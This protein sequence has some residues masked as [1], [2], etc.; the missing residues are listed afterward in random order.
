MWGSGGKRRVLP[1]LLARPR[2]SP[3]RRPLR[4]SVP[5]RVVLS[6]LPEARP[7]TPRPSRW[8]RGFGGGVR[9]LLRKLPPPPPPRVLTP[10]AQATT[11]FPPLTAAD[12]AARILWSRLAGCA[13]RRVAAP[14]RGSACLAPPPPAAGPGPA[15]LGRS[16]VVRRSGPAA[17]VARR[18]P[19]PSEPRG[20]LPLPVPHPHHASCGRLSGS[21]ALF[22]PLPCL[23]R[24][25]LPAW[26]PASRR[27]PFPPPSV[28]VW[29][30]GCPGTRVRVG[31]PPRGGPGR[32]DGVRRGRPHRGV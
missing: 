9:G 18:L 2:P 30:E 24:V 16:S 25:P 20:C 28:V 21:P 19:T 31:H 23:G 7:S 8:A 29:G 5:R 10:V 11:A 17:P 4:A 1:R 3:R 27:S 15:C 6:P 12:R 26:R 14:R 13:A 32:E 22:S